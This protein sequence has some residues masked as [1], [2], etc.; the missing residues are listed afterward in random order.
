MLGATNDDEAARAAFCATLA[1]L[2]TLLAQQGHLVLVAATAPR[3]AP[4]YVVRH[5]APRYV[6]V[7]V[8]TAQVDCEA[9]D[10]KGL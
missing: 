8:R 6:E 1:A 10:V 5:G 7:W 3:L 4:R 2:A 9:R